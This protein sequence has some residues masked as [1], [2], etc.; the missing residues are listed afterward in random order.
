LEGSNYYAKEENNLF[1]VDI[2]TRRR[3]AWENLS[4]GLL[5]VRRLLLPKEGRASILRTTEREERTKGQRPKT[6]IIFSGHTSEMR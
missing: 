2:I 6:E 4:S 3:A 1:L 5:G